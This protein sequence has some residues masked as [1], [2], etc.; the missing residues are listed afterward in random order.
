MISIVIPAYREGEVL[1]DFLLKLYQVCRPAEC[2]VVVA[3]DAT[4]FEA[5]RTQ[6]KLRF[7]EVN[8]R[9]VK[10]DQK[11]RA[12]QMN[13][14]ARAA[15]GSTILFLHADTYLPE[16]AMGIIQ[17]GIDTGSHWGRF[18]VQFDNSRWPYPMIAAMMNLR[19]CSTG[20]ATGDQAI[21][22]TRTTFNLAGGFDEIPLMEDIEMSKKLKRI[23]RPLCVK[24]KVL[25]SARRW[26]RKGVLK[27]IL[28][29]WWLRLANYLGVSPK[30]L[31]SWYR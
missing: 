20:I 2:I 31:E 30:T 12:R 24:S 28:L 1:I 14:G 23:G 7:S 8:L 22:M 13:Q 6:T 17:K 10:A 27:T 3:S 5:L 9:V 19:S 15:S 11:G 21:F 25:T 18:N 26:E 29:M 16:G 4:E